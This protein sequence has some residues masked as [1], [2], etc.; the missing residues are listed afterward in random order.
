MASEFS[1]DV[2]AQY[3]VQELR[4]AV[5]QVKREIANR[6]DFKDSHTEVTL[7]EE[8]ITVLAPDTMKLKAVQ[9][10]LFQKLVNRK[11]SPKILDIKEHEPAAQGALRQLMKLIKVLDQDKCKLITKYI[12]DNFPK[13][14]SSIQG[15][16]VRISSKN[17][18]DLQAV[19]A[20]LRAYAQLDAP[21][22]FT[23][24]R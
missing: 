17:K 14:K 8:D 1:F 9:E 10:M 22:S 23:N 24:F 6:Y 7:G 12:K 20:G 19:M 3:D 16:E 11:L 4:N 21:I 13:V 2:V 15:N 5:E 18:D